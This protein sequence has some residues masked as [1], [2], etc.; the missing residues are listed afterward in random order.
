MRHW[1][2][3]VVERLSAGP[4]VTVGV[5]RVDGAGAIAGLDALF[6]FD[7]LFVGRDTVLAADLAD[8]APLPGPLAA[9]DLILDLAGGV[10]AADLPVLRPL[11]LG[12]PPLVGALAAVLAD[13]VPVGEVVRTEPGADPRPVERWALAVEERS[14]TLRAVSQILARIAHMTVTA[15]VDR[16]GPPG[17]RRGF[18]PAAADAVASPL[19]VPA[20]FL[21][22]LGV[23][24]G[25]R[26]DRLVRDPVD[27]RVIT[28]L[29]D[30]AADPLAP[31]RD[32]TPFRTLVDDGGR[33]YADPF[34]HR[35]AGR[36]WLFVEEF[37]YATGRGVLSVAEIAA[38]GT[39]GTPRPFLEQGCHLSYPQVFAADGEIWMVPETSGRRTVELWRAV[40]FPDRWEKHAVLVDDV[41]LGD[42]T[43][44]R[45]DDGWWMFGCRREPGCSSWDALEIR[46]APALIGPWREIA[47]APAKVDVATARPAGAMI[48]A[49]GALLR[50]TQNSSA[51]YGCGLGLA[52]VDR[53]GRDGFAETELRRLF[54]PA[55]IAGLHTWNRAATPTGLVEV[56]DV[57][58][59]AADLGTTRR[60]A[61]EA[62][63][64]DRLFET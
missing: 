21:R 10:E 26:L 34:V 37:P 7:R 59:R 42:A 45:R 5:V 35:E 32:P 40:A 51:G 3:G 33:F 61:F 23:R 48:V 39:I 38:D 60:F 22:S 28:R 49:G 56:M 20:A 24:V 64:P 11:C 30:P 41:D 13:R 29:R 12:R 19:A 17:S 50:P 2:T 8:G 47:P 27:W 4:G 63:G 53:L 1:Q 16:D 31:E 52:R 58:A 46:H 54:P 18:A 9:P 57:F 6:A 36:T 43:L 62:I 55:P 44:L 25:R 15:V 14:N